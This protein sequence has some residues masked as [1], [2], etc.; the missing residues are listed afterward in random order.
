MAVRGKPKREQTDVGESG[1]G[2]TTLFGWKHYALFPILGV[3]YATRQLHCGV[4]ENQDVH[5]TAGIECRGLDKMCDLLAC[6]HM[7]GTTRMR[8]VRRCHVSSSFGCPQPFLVDLSRPLELDYIFHAVRGPRI[9]YGLVG[10]DN[11]VG[12]YVAFCVAVTNPCLQFG[13]WVGGWHGAGVYLHDVMTASERLRN[14]LHLAG[15]RAQRRHCYALIHCVG[16]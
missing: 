14:R 6:G 12:G 3:M 11:Q 15:C 9:M 7:L 13:G 8:I 2:C 4:N 5:T 10:L 1:D 16:A